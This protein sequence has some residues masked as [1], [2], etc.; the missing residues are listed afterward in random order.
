[1]IRTGTA[2]KLRILGATLLFAF[3][4]SAAPAP[5]ALADRTLPAIANEAK[6]KGALQ[7]I[8]QNQWS[9]GESI[10]AGTT[11]GTL[12]AEAYYWLKYTKNAPPVSFDRISSFIK[13]HENWPKLREMKSNAEAA[14]PL[15]MPSREVIAWFD[16]F[17]PVTHQATERYIDALMANG[18]RD[19]ATNVIRE[20]WHDTLS[21]AS[22]QREFYQKYKDLLR[23]EDHRTRLNHLLYND[24][25]TTARNLAAVMGPA[26]QALTE[27]RIATAAAAGNANGLI[28]QVPAELQ[29]DPGLLYERLH[30]RRQHDMNDGMIEILKQQPPAAQ[31]TNQEGWW[32]ER[33]ILIRRL[34]DQGNYPLAYKIAAEHGFTQGS[35]M[36]DAEFMAGWLALSYLK[37]PDMAFPHFTRLYENVVTPISKARGAYWAGEAAAKM[38]Q[39][40]LSEQWYKAAA[41]R[42]PAF[43]GALAQRKLSGSYNS[44]PPQVTATSWNQW[45]SDP[46][47]RMAILFFRSGFRAESLSFFL[48]MA[49]DKNLREGDYATLFEIAEQ[50][51]DHKSAVKVYKK[52]AFQGYSLTN[53]GY[54]QAQ[55]PQLS[56]L[57]SSVVH[58]IIRQESEFDSQAVS[59]ANAYGLMQ[60]IPSTAQ[61][62][63]KRIG[64]SHDRRWLTSRPEHNVQLG[65]AYLRELLDKYDGAL[66][67][68]AAAYNAGPSN[69]SKWIAQ[70]GDPRN[71]SVSTIDW[72]ERIPFPETRNYVQRIL[73]GYMEYERR[74]V[75]QGSP[76]NYPLRTLIR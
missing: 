71:P 45:T 57:P 42:Q 22:Q 72:I 19:K 15:N 27:A 61:H 3:T 32:R 41:A 11:G 34:M 47:T 74:H 35:E 75:R 8:E 39:S 13:S 53:F 17:S 24:Y 49:E 48:R 25:T 23:F 16:R 10:L 29:R 18:Q 1:M 58:A 67:L 2:R 76:D 37:K 14:M 44:A 28:A 5:T 68:A 56:G 38:G 6:I 36:A 9:Y 54:P 46:R 70:Y 64:V 51:G 62:S 63:A 55:F 20:W 65:S 73:E 26:Y 7:A 30:F 69:V 50:L 59:H 21:S 4:F 33:H 66:P 52:A 43:Y 60:L 12:S 40:S 31:L